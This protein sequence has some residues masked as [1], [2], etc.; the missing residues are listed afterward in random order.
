LRRFTNVFHFLYIICEK[1]QKELYI[2]IFLYIH[3]ALLW[4]SF[5]GEVLNEIVLECFIKVWKILFVTFCSIKF[6]T[7]SIK[8][9]MRQSSLSAINNIRKSG[10]FPCIHNSWKAEIWIWF[11]NSWKVTSPNFLPFHMRKV[12]ESVH[13][14][15]YNSRIVLLKHFHR[16]V[17]GK[18]IEFRE[19]LRKIC[20]RNPNFIENL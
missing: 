2:K 12:L 1:R 4:K 6:T 16:I 19:Y 9:L 14:P 17:C 8:K 10:Q 7:F 15:L 18:W 5:M 3:P 13:F 20:I 11:H